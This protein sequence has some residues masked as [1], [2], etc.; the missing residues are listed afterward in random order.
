M[1]VF[2]RFDLARSIKFGNPRAD[3]QN[4]FAEMIGNLVSAVCRRISI[5]K[6]EAN[7]VTNRFGVT[8][9]GAGGVPAGAACF[10]AW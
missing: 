4:A 5:T 6:E 1:T 8:G 7:A 9:N 2:R 10:E 3:C